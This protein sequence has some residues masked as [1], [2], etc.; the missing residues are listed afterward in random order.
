MVIRSLPELISHGILVR[1]AIIGIGEDQAYLT[2]L[3]RD[4]G[5]EGRV[6]LLGHV[7]PEDLPRWYNACDVFAMPNREINGDTEGFGMV[8][9]EAAACGK[10][11]IAGTAGGTGSAVIEGVTGQRIDGNSIDEIVSHLSELLSNPELARV[12]GAHG[13]ERAL[14]EYS[15]QRV[16]EKTIAPI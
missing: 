2:N 15:W 4:L 13:H 5:V 12:L 9:L 14:Q 6:H 16:A 10:P 3:S 7:S 1:Y 11:V 8:F